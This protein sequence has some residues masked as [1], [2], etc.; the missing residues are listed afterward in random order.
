VAAVFTLP[1]YFAF[2]I[3]L[4]IATA[5]VVLLAFNRSPSYLLMTR[6][7]EARI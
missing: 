6:V 5:H 7:R 2:S 3:L 4:S 1:I